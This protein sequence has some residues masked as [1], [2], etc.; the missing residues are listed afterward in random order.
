M[1]FYF[2]AVLKIIQQMYVVNGP[3]KYPKKFWFPFIIY[4]MAQASD[5][6][7]FFY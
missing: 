6:T 5:D 2:S 3:K 1:C 7:L 4:A